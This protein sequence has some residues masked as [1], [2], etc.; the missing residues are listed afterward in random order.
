MVLLFMYSDFLLCVKAACL[1]SRMLLELIM[2]NVYKKK[3]WK[4]IYTNRKD[5]LGL[6]EVI[7]IEERR[8][9][10]LGLNW[11]VMRKNILLVFCSFSVLHVA[12]VGGLL[13]R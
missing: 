2:Y 6:Y 8:E 1:H 9:K 3:K 11:I 10:W 13:T 4:Y 7:F 5:M 12:S